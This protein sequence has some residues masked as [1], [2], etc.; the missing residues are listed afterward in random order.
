MWGIDDEYR[1]KWTTMITSHPY[2]TRYHASRERARRD[3]RRGERVIRLG[4]F[5]NGSFGLFARLD[6]RG[7]TIGGP[8]T[9]IIVWA[10]MP[11]PTRRARRKGAN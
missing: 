4:G 7:R 5:A 2:G 11:A 6:S 8:N 10:V 1:G 3:R 9:G